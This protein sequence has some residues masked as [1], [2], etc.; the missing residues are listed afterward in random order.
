MD[1]VVSIINRIEDSCVLAYPN[2]SL[3]ACNTTRM[4]HL[5]KMPLND[6]NLE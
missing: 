6:I 3:I 4:M 2:P 1:V 5:K